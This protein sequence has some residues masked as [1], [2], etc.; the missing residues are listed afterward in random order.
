MARHFKHAE[1]QALLPEIERAVRNAV[2]LKAVYQEAEEELRRAS[3]RIMM[4]GGSIVDRQSILAV[5]GRRDTTAAQLKEA[6]ETVREQGCLIKDLDIG[7]VDFPTYYRGNE[8]YLCW[9]LGE[10]HIGYWHGVDEGF[11]GRKPIDQDF[12]DN[13]EGERP[14]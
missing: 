9:K 2:Q 13:H 1:A 10:D 6:I 14:N 11:R 12:L 3:Q 7:L 4:L 5:R 8:V